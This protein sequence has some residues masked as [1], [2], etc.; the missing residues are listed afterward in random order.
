MRYV[1]TAAVTSHAAL[2]RSPRFSASHPNALAPTTAT[3]IHP[4]HE[5]NFLMRVPSLGG[6]VAA[7]LSRRLRVSNRG[8]HLIFAL[9]TFAQPNASC[10]DVS[11]LLHRLRTARIARARRKLRASR[12][13]VLGVSVE[14]GAVRNL[15]AGGERRAGHSAGSAWAARIRAARRAAGSDAADDRARLEQQGR[16]SP[17]IPRDGG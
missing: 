9:V 13:N 1:Q 2:T 6:Y 3:R 8:C 16:R 10:D 5:S 14:R 11:T 12:R 17:R 15:S 4:S 7:K